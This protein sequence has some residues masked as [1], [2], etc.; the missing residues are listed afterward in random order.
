MA[1]DWRD[2]LQSLLGTLPAGE[3]SPEP[4]A[5]ED[6]PKPHK[7]RL[8]IIVDRKGRNGK[9]ATIISGFT[10]DDEEVARVAAELRRRLGTGGSARG[11]EILIQG[12]RRYDAEDFL[13]ARGFKCRI[14]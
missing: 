3:D 5:A 11:G 7:G 8:D 12:D 9:T 10:A 13:K 1:D 4:I 14:I 6:A 2:S